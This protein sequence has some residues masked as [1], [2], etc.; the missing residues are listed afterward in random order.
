MA[1]PLP[2]LGAVLVTGFALG[3]STARAAGAPRERDP[4]RVA[5]GTRMTSAMCAEGTHSSHARAS[6]ER[7]E[8]ERANT[9]RP[10]RHGAEVATAA[11]WFSRALASLVQPPLSIAPAAPAAG[12]ERGATQPTDDELPWCV[13]AEDPRCAPLH[14]GAGPLGAPARFTATPA[15]GG[16]ATTPELRL[17]GQNTTPRI[18]LAPR[19][20]VKHRVERPPRATG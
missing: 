11:S 8:L 7:S 20:G 14:H 16:A 5:N 3:A 4:A 19:L 1:R 10:N 18:G 13:S 6:R 9:E 15:Y 2:L 12:D 17:V